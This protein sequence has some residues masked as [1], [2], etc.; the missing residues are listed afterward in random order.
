MDILCQTCDEPWDAH[1]LRY[2]A[3]HE[4][5]LPEKQCKNWNGQLTP[6]IREE[7]R[8]ARYAF[9]SSIYSLRSCPCCPKGAKPSEAGRK[10]ALFADTAADL[11]GD[12]QDGLLAEIS[13][14]QDLEG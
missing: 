12:D 10:R 13:D 2:D 1:H 5:G 6:A 3:I 11:L 14:F 4:T 8:G 9:G 7:F